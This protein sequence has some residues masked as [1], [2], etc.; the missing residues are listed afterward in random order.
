MLNVMEQL[1][2]CSPEKIIIVG[3]SAGGNLVSALLNLLI[4]WDLRQPDGI[5]MVYP[6]LNL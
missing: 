3:D 5:V 6:A 4:E 2:E 1:Y